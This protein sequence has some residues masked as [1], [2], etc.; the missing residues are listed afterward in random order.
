[1]RACV[2]ITQHGACMERRVVGAPQV[3]Y[4]MQ[5]VDMALLLRKGRGL[6]TLSQ[7][8]CSLLAVQACPH[9]HC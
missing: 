9:L 7:N 3:C 2:H 1:M 4:V 6:G 8:F 5:E